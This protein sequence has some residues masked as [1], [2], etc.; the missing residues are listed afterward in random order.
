MRATEWLE[1]ARVSCTNSSETENRNIAITEEQGEFGGREE[2]VLGN[3]FKPFPITLTPTSPTPA[4]LTL[5][6]S[7][8]P[9][10]TTMSC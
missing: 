7:P 10:P 4:C 1:K 2:F 5:T 8:T 3:T 9:T 6:P